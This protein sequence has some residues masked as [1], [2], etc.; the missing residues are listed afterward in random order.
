VHLLHLHL[1]LHPPLQA[2]S[3]L[4]EVAGPQ[5][6]RSQWRYDSR[7][8]ALVQL[9]AAEGPVLLRAQLD[10][11]ASDE[12]SRVPWPEAGQCVFAGLQRL[13]FLWAVVGVQVQVGDSAARAG[14]RRERQQAGGGRLGG[15]AR[16]VLTALAQQVW[17]FHACQHTISTA[18]ITA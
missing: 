4:V 17:A 7:R 15:S 2:G 6:R 10:L 5:G 13:V 1:H 11:C 8:G 9:D 14:A 16:R 12:A 3:N 18:R